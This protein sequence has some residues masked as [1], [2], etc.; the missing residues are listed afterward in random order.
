[1][2][3][4]VPIKKV[5]PDVSQ[6]RKYF[7]VQKLAELKKSMKVHGIISP[8]VVQEEADH[9]LLVDG[10]RRFRAAVELGFKEVPVTVL[11][12]TDPITRMIE[13]FHLQQMHENW[14]PTEEASVITEVMNISKANFVQTCEML[15]INP[16]RARRLYALSKISDKEGFANNNV[17]LAFA[18]TIQNVTAFVRNMKKEMEEEF[19]KSDQKKLERAIISR[20]GSGELDKKMDINQLKDIFRV[21]PKSYDKFLAGENT[22]TLFVKSKARATYHLRNAVYNARLMRMN[23]QGFLKNPN[24]ALTDAEVSAFTEARAEIT[25]LL[26]KA[27]KDE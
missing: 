18:E 5:V 26:S 8:L 16:Q 7:D 1:M 21:D 27:G 20:V 15:N 23:L 22:E 17:P 14:T 13:Q 24:V 9:Y 3:N 4:L 12:A 19:L 10:E 11:T 6:P 2:S 25:K